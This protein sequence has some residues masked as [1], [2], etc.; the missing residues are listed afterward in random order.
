MD[1]FAPAR[2]AARRSTLNFQ[3]SLLSVSL[4]NEALKKAQRQRAPEAGLEQ[5]GPEP[6]EVVVARATPRSARSVALI[7]LGAGVTVLAAAL[8]TYFLTTGAATVVTGPVPPKSKPKSVELKAAPPEAVAANAASPTQSDA[9]KATSAAPTPSTSAP[10]PTVPPA[11]SQAASSP[12]TAPQ[13]SPTAPA[14]ADPNPAVAVAPAPPTPVAPLP[15]TVVAPA[16][17]KPSE[18][19]QAFVD[20]VRVAGIRA[21]GDDSRVLM[22]G[23]QYRLNEIVDRSLGIKLVKVEGNCLTFADP[24]GVIYR[25]YF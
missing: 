22:N 21:S 3:L 13:E 20:A 18:Q 25:K 12:S 16:P 9:A 1:Q 7:T 2:F 17:P 8:L 23:R 14:K 19:V 6:G 11:A 24:S 10:E 5:P 4:I 15:Q